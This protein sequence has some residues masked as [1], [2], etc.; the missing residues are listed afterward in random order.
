[1]HNRVIIVPIDG[2]RTAFKAVKYAAKLAKSF[3]DKVSIIKRTT[4]DRF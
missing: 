2:S 3:Q 4:N 1:M